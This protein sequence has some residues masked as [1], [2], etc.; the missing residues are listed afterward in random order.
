M[1]QKDLELQEL[2]DRVQEIKDKL[3]EKEYELQLKEYNWAEFEKIIIHFVREDEEIMAMLNDVGYLCDDPSSKRKISTVV[4][5]NLKL[6]TKVHKLKNKLEEARSNASWIDPNENKK[7]DTLK[8]E[9]DNSK[10]RKMS[11]IF[12]NNDNLGQL[13]GMLYI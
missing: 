3:D 2:K 12:L 7:D 8:A 13:E 6:K 5:E 4:T 10:K 11:A 1:H 9:K